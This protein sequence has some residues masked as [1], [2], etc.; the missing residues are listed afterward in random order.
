MDTTPSE[1]NVEQFAYHLLAEFE[2]LALTEKCP[3]TR[4][5]PQKPK[6]QEAEKPKVS[7]FKKLEEET[8]S[9]PRREV[10]REEK[11]KCKLY[12]SEQGCRRGK[13]CNWSHDQK[14]ERRRC[15]NCGSPGHMAP[16]CTRPKEQ[17]D[18]SPTKPRIQKVEGED[19]SS[20]SS[21]VK[22]EEGSIEGPSIKEL[23]EQANTMLK[24]LTSTAASSK[25]TGSATDSR[26]DVMERLQTQLDQLK[27]KVFK[28]QPD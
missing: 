7:K 5:D 14:D 21:K 25:S 24:S 15:W 13:A 19:S 28:D 12:L 18:A 16:A 26:E 2:Q 10:S 8:K 4:S 23:L 1:V 9:P 11:P 27:L 17:G 20:T 22:E 6:P 3:G